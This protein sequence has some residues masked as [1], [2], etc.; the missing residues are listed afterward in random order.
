MSKTKRSHKNSERHLSSNFW[1][2]VQV[3]LGRN[4][5]GPQT[6]PRYFLD[7]QERA[8]SVHF[9]ILTLGTGL[10][11]VGNCQL[12]TNRKTRGGA[13]TRNRVARV[14]PGSA[15]LSSTQA[16]SVGTLPFISDT[17]CWHCGGCGVF[18]RLLSDGKKKG[19]GSHC[20]AAGTA[21]VA[22]GR[23]VRVGRRGAEQISAYDVAKPPPLCTGR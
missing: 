15:D 23:C 17:S 20:Q 14:N 21:T 19:R 22:A 18:E 4:Y 2:H 7:F 5:A 10:E 3:D 9:L 6:K 16:Y 13:L 12:Q 11:G 8:C 1:R